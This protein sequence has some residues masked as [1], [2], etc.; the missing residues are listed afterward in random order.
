MKHLVVFMAV[1]HTYFYVVVYT[2]RGCRTSKF[3]MG[4]SRWAQEQRIKGCREDK[5]REGE[6]AKEGK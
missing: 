1:V 6:G 5:R 2:Q 3:V 4:I